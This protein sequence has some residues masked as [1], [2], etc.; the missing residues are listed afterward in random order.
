GGVSPRCSRQEKP[1]TQNR[2][3]T[4]PLPTVVSGTGNQEA[5]N[6]GLHSISKNGSTSQL[7]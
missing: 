7:S 1:H 4:S 3:K 6:F 5:K 2:A